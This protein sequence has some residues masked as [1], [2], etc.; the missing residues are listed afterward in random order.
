[1]TSRARREPAVA[2]EAP[3]HSSLRGAAKLSAAQALFV[4]AGYILNVVLARY[5]GPGPYGVYGIVVSLLTIVNLMQ[6]QGV[7]QALSR[8]I[9]GGSDEAAA[10]RA[11]LHVQAVAS[12]GGL[13][14]LAVSAPILASVLDDERLLQ[15]APDRRPGRAELRAVRDARRRSERSPRLRAT[16]ADERRVRRRA[17][18]LRARPGLRVPVR[19]RDRGLRDR[20]AGRVRRGVVVAAARRPAGRRSTG[21]RWCGSRCRTSGSRWR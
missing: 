2:D 18:G 1:M 13:V 8:A 12:T 4:L 9:A 14:L 7:P 5:L 21:R 20:A 3:R 16:G 19:R 15:R 10:W 6:T 17:G 11:A